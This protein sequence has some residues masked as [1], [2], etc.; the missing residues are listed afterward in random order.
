MAARREATAAAQSVRCQC[1]HLQAGRNVLAGKFVSQALV[2]IFILESS[3]TKLERIIH[4]RHP[5]R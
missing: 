4:L 3:F 2:F 5:M 1:V